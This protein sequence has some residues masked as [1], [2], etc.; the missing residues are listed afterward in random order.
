ME[1]NAPY[2]TL[3]YLLKNHAVGQMRTGK[4]KQFVFYFGDVVMKGPYDEKNST[5][6]PSMNER[7]A[8]FT[9]WNVPHV[10]RLKQWVRNGDGLFAVFRNKAFGRGEQEVPY[11]RMQTQVT[12][13]SFGQ[14]LTYNTV[15]N[16][17]LL[18][19]LHVIKSSGVRSE[20]TKK[21]YERC[22]TLLIALCVE[23]ILRVEAALPA[24]PW[25]C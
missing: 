1:Y 4:A 17:P 2:I 3:D 18:D 8:V 5:R 13:E 20:M 15:L 16:S 11:N 9:E 25:I 14:G 6:V 19:L 21:I 22:E 7:S 12:I 24:Y 10:V 23:F